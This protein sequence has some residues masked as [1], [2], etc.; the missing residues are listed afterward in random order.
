M[1]VQQEQEQGISRK[2]S[3]MILQFSSNGRTRPGRLVPPEFQRVKTDR[4]SLDITMKI[5]LFFHRAQC[6]ESIP[7]QHYSTAPS[8]SYILPHE[9]R[10]PSFYFTS[11]G[12][13]VDW[14]RLRKSS[15]GQALAQE[16]MDD[17]MFGQVDGPLDDDEAH[18]KAKA[19]TLLQFTCQ[20]VRYCTDALTSERRRLRKVHGQ[21]QR[22]ALERLESQKIRNAAKIQQIRQQVQADEKNAHSL[23]SLVRL[24]HPSVD[25]SYF[26]ACGG[27][28]SYDTHL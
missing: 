26:S 22:R 8:S 13:H 4:S 15:P 5:S 12:K 14:K 6:L 28:N 18:R 16:V 2:A 24:H 19:L 3:W 11:C 23:E 9:S 17:I 25:L 27:P 1:L 21:D 20:Y 7:V 10:R